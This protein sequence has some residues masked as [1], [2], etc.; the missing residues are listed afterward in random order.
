[1][2]ELPSALVPRVLG[3]RALQ[4]A[5][6]LVRASGLLP[7][8]IP[9]GRGDERRLKQ[10]PIDAEVIVYFADT[11]VGLYQ[12]RPWFAPLRA[13]H[14]VHPVVII[15]TDSRAVRAIRRESGLP[16]YTIS[17]YS[18]IE[19]VL[20]KTAARLALYVNHNAANFSL[21]AFPQLVHVSI[22]HGDSDKFVSI[23]G[24]T[25]AYDFTFVAG[26]AAVDRLAAYLPLYDAA[27]RCVI[28]GRPQVPSLRPGGGRPAGA[29]VVSHDRTA[30]GTGDGAGMRCGGQGGGVS[31]GRP[32]GRIVV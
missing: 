15:G 11:L 9:D 1:M 7:K 22:M 6:W 4:A 2:S 31:G 14:K 29:G 30:G 21:L 20:D 3:A 27:S 12:L 5:V 25:K 32:A 19:L 8:G 28:V 24:Q 13:L 10:D 16:A 18:S 17:H 23:S 26:Q